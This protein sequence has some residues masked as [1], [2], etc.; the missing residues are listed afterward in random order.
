MQETLYHLRKGKRQCFMG[1]KKSGRREP[2]DR[3]KIK[4]GVLRAIEKRPISLEYVN[5]LVDQVE[6]EMLRHEREE[7]SSKEIGSAV[8]KRL[9]KVDRVAW[10]RFASVYL[11]FEVL[12][13]FEKAIEGK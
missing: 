10:L 4:R 11:E 2:F 5:E 12:T 7:V 6:R 3:E 8:L 1:G 13:D 9:K